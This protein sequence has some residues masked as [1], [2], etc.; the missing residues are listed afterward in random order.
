MLFLSAFDFFYVGNLNS[1]LFE[2]LESFCSRVD[3]IK[4]LIVIVLC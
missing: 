2:E 3:T 1:E 4:V